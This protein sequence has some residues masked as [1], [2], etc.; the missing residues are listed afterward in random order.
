MSQLL[1]ETIKQAISESATATVV[2]NDSFRDHDDLLLLD[3]RSD[4]AGFALVGET[5]KPSYEKAYLHFKT[6]YRDNKNAWDK[7]S[8]SFVLCRLDHSLEKDSFFSL[9]ESDPY[10]CRKYVIRYSNDPATFVKEIGRLPFL[11]LPRV[12]DSSFVRPPSA[13]QVLQALEFPSNFTRALVEP[14]KRSAKSL[15]EDVKKNALIIPS[16]QTTDIKSIGKLAMVE[17]ARRTRVKSLSVEAFRAYRNIESFDLSA[18]ITVLYGQNGL[19]KTSLFDAIDFACTGRIGRLFRHQRS[20]EE[21]AD[22]ATHLDR[23][24]AKANVRIELACSEG[25]NEVT[26]NAQRSVTDWNYAWIGKTRYDRRAFLQHLSGVSSVEGESSLDVKQLESLFRATHL[27]GQDDQE[28]LL[29]FRQKS[30]IPNDL[31][32]R[33]LALD[34]YTE[35]INKTDALEKELKKWSQETRE[36]SQ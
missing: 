2:P 34:D 35:A 10:F 33:M 28:L 8:L 18:P 4:I 32:S 23:D 11:P 1:F 24:A 21:F 17:T 19:G 9:V 14:R 5:A 36:Q 16:V 15:A 27:F 26:E 30:V 22:L 29:Q 13:K 12:G 6:L 20:P 3:W 31:F 7:R 25:D